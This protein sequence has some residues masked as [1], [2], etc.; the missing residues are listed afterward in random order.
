MTTRPFCRR[1]HVSVTSA[2]VRQRAADNLGPAHLQEWLD[3]A[4]ADLTTAQGEVEW[5][6][7]LLQRRTAEVAAGT[8]SPP[9]TESRWKPPSDPHGSL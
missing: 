5:L 2:S 9:S 7:E 8:W 3:R 6:A 1:R 4:Q